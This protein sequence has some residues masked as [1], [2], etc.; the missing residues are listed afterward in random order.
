[1]KRNAAFSLT[2]LLVVIAIL[3]IVSGILV[4]IFIGGFRIFNQQSAIIETQ[5][6]A[7]LVTSTITRD[8]Q[9]ANR[10]LESR[11]FGTDTYITSSDT[12][13][14]E[15]PSIDSSQ[16]IIEGKFDYEV[17]YL[18]PIEPQKLKLKRETAPESSRRSETKTIANLI[19]NL[20]FVYKKGNI[21]V[22]PS[23]SEIITIK[24]TNSKTSYGKLYS[25]SL[26]GQA[27]LRN[28]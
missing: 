15:L 19:E 5:G 11:T 9:Q 24:V 23:E 10:V 20:T 1:V 2:E 22:L 3:T 4:G 27:K 16:N 25:T 26:T 13:I 18:D 28:K 21:E 12:L 7:K 17:F 14:L 6:Q 8:V